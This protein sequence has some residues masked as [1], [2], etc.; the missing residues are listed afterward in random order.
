M[1]SIACCFLTVLQQ[2]FSARDYNTQFAIQKDM[3][4]QLPIAPFYSHVISHVHLSSRYGF[5]GRF[6]SPVTFLLSSCP[7]IGTVLLERLSSNTYPVPIIQTTSGRGVTY[8][9]FLSCPNLALRFP[10]RA[11]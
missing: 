9:C 10:C 11:C 6:M 4:T 8:A 7:Q 2:S 3:K 5:N 1:F